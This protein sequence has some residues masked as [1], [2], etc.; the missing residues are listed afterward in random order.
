MRAV[1]LGLLRSRT[2]VALL[3]AAIVLSAV[4]IA[5]IFGDGSSSTSTTP[6]ALTEQTTSGPSVSFTPGRD[7]G[8]ISAVPTVTPSVAQGALAPTRVAV[9]FTANWLKRT[10]PAEEWL[11]A[12][13][14]HST[15]QLIDQLDDVDP[16]T[17]PASRISGAATMVTL[18]ETAVQITVPLDSG[19]LMLRMVGPA[20]HWFVDG[21]DWE[22]L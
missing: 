11:N 9:A 1:I 15:Q 18:S 3:L 22:R 12:L 10:R 4:G 13:R 14:P 2:G 21:V 20:G 7:D 16:Q 17:V 19:R 6:S 8:V 5:R